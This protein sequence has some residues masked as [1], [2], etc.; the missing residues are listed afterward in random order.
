MTRAQQETAIP[1]AGERFGSRRPEVLRSDADMIRFGRELGLGDALGVV[2]ELMVA[3]P[4]QD[5]EAYAALQRAYDD[6]KAVRAE[7]GR[8]A[9]SRKVE[10]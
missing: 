7:L 8:A 1:P 2:H 9:A 10:G 4:Y 5:A 6:I 3:T